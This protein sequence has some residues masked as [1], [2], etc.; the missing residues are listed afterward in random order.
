MALTAYI[1]PPTPYAPVKGTTATG[2]KS[3]SANAAASC[4]YTSQSGTWA[5]YATLTVDFP[6]GYAPKTLSGSNWSPDVQVTC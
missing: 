4:E 6:P 2:T 5:G 1:Y 3:V